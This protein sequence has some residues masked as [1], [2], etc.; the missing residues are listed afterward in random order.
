MKKK[1][2]ASKAMKGM[3]A[4]KSMKEM[5]AMKKKKKLSIIARGR[6]AKSQV[7]KGRKVKTVGGLKKEALMKN[8]RGK[9]VSKRQNVH[10]NHAYK[11]VR[12]WVDSVMSAR[13]SL[14][15]EGFVA[16]NG[17]NAQGKALYVKAKALWAAA[18][19]N[20]ASIAASAAATEAVEATVAA[21]ESLTAS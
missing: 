17:K 4:M 3:K 16:I 1:K 13:R 5:K 18:S 12:G 8:K 7:L 19:A 15:L 20:A 14:G 10:G 2:K 9:V 11:N 21:T 6:L